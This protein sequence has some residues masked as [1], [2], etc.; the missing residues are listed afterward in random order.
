MAL[1]ALLRHWPDVELIVAHFDHGIRADAEEDRK[2]VAATA[3]SYQLPFYYREG[4]LGPE[5]SEAHAR[6]ARYN[7]LEHVRAQTG[8][9]AIITAHHQDDLIETVIL[10]VLRGTGRKGLAGLTD[11]PT[12]LRPLLAVSKQELLEYAQN[13][14]LEWRE[15]STNADDRYTRN[16]IR[17]HL[18]PRLS[19]D[20]KATLL[21]IADHTRKNNTA[22][23]AV[24]SDLLLPMADGHL[25]RHVFIQLPHAASRELLA[26]WLRT[27]DITKFDTPLLERVTVAVKTQAPGAIIDLIGGARLRVAKYTLALEHS[28]R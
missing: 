15:D 24:L 25:D 5:T 11:R 10:N 1:L 16:Y 14:Q 21:E 6:E 2:L 3:A 12:V 8:A 28:E 17:H 13:H 9:R 19:P 22:L 26:S 4:K 18:V 7:F 27:H 23:D 20:A